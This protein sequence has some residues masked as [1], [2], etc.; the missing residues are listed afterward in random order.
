MTLESAPSPATRLRLWSAPKCPGS[1]TAPPSS[2]YLTLSPG[3]GE[4]LWDKIREPQRG[5]FWCIVTTGSVVFLP[6]WPPRD[7]R[8]DG[9]AV[10]QGGA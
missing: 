8:A 10:R 1:G 7:P 5:H 3:A 9:E 6:V 2:A 4:V